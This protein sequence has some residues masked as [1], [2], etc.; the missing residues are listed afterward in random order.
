MDQK[1]TLPV[2]A[3]PPG[4]Y[5]RRYFDDLVRSLNQLVF[6]LRIPGEGRNTTLTLTNLPTSSYGLEP[7]ALF[8]VGNTVKITLEYEAY[9]IGLQAQSSV[10]TVTVTT[11]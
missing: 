2:F 4:E 9:P 8:R 11:V 10:G 6:L 3:R 5:E 1:S 7:G